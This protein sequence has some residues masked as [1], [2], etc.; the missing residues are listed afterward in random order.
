MPKYLENLRHSVFEKR[1]VLVEIP[2]V[3]HVVG[4]NNGSGAVSKIKCLESICEL[5]DLFLPAAIKFYLDSAGINQIADDAI[6]NTSYINTGKQAMRAYNKP[7][8][9]NVFVVNKVSENNALGIYDPDEDWILI[10][11]GA[12]GTGKKVLAHEMGHFFS[13]L[14]THFGWDGRPWTMAYDN[15]Q[16][17]SLSFDGKTPTE[18]V[19]RLNCSV[20]GDMLCDTP[21]DYNFGL[22]FQ[23]SCTF[24]GNA[25]DPNGVPV[26]PNT[27]LLMSYFSDDCRNT[28]SEE[29]ILVMR[30]DL[31]RDERTLLYDQIPPDNRQIN[32]IPEVFYPVLEV[33]ASFETD[34]LNF[35]WGAV[36]G[37]TYYYMVLDRSSKF[38]LEPIEI[39][40]TRPSV[41]VDFPF[42]ENTKY[43]W[44]VMAYNQHHTCNSF[45]DVKTFTLKR[46]TSSTSVK[47]N[48]EFEVRYAS[49]IIEISIKT[50][51]DSLSEIWL[52]NASGQKV[53]QV[54][55]FVV[56]QE[57]KIHL[58]YP[59]I[60]HGVYYLTLVG[61][62]KFATKK[63]W[64]H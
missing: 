5:N 12:I 25:L 46:T 38:D 4:R 9:I 16:V 22:N 31:N 36:D 43:Y 19:N 42:L 52:L 47:N 30:A 58:F 14:H 37:A 51:H 2:V 49:Q 60:P 17:S 1:S 56:N 15:K 20:A 27:K 50:I 39:I 28:F 18:L 44:K 13:L 63:L 45:S 29:Q 7:N 24:G 54:K 61:N 21:A 32:Q 26:I 34:T 41:I 3:F 62:H 64:V 35:A 59:T 33:S 10:Q 11:K 40:T 23:N 53:L 8:A 55:D 57:N 48:V 6:F